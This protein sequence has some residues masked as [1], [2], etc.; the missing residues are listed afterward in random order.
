[1]CVGAEA[2]DCHLSDF[3][4]IYLKTAAQEVF[5]ILEGTS[6]KRPLQFIKI[7]LYNYICYHNIASFGHCVSITRAPS[8]TS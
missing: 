4:Y 2:N 8:R 3:A 1:M 7:L 5:P 6:I